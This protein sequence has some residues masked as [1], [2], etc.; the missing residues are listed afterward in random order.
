MSQVQ[1]RPFSVSNGRTAT[2]WWA[3]LTIL[4]ELK[5]KG[6]ENWTEEEREK[7]DQLRELA[8]NWVTCAVGNQCD[9]IPRE[10]IVPIDAELFSAGLAFDRHVKDLNIEQAVST[11]ERIEKRSEYLIK[12]ILATNAKTS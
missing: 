11:L 10:G 7:C 6:E 5:K 1:E 2:N 4:D 3:E 9:I 8:G 12:K